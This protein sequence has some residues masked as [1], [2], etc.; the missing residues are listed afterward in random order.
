MIPKKLWTGSVKVVGFVHLYTR[1]CNASQWR[2]I[3]GL[4]VWDYLIPHVGPMVSQGHPAHKPL[5][6]RQRPDVCFHLAEA[7][8]HCTPQV[9]CMPFRQCQHLQPLLSTSTPELLGRAAAWLCPLSETS[10]SAFVSSCFATNYAAPARLPVEP[11]QCVGCTA[12]GIP[13]WSAWIYL[14]QT[15]RNI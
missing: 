4:K 7:S 13:C 15:E 8:M 3:V 10:K 2:S 12:L 1:H 5:L 9:I 14:Q 6:L 11:D